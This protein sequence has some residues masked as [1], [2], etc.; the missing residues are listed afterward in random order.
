M[1]SASV[2][3]VRVN[4]TESPG[5]SSS[6]TSWNG[7]VTAAVRSGSPST[8]CSSARESSSAPRC[9]RTSR[10]VSVSLPVLVS[11]PLTVTATPGSSVR[12]SRRVSRTLTGR[13][14]AA[15]S[16][17]AGSPG[18]AV[19]TGGSTASGTL[20]TPASARAIVVP[21]VARR[22]PRTADRPGTDRRLTTAPRR[23][24]SPRGRLLCSPVSSPA[25]SRAVGE[26]RGRPLDQRPLVGV[27]EPGAELVEG[28]PGDLGH[29]DV[30]VGQSSPDGAQQEVVHGL[31]HPAAVGDEPEVDDA[32][33]GDDLADDA[34]L[35]G[36]LPDGGVL[37]G[38]ALLDV[39]LG[40]RPQQPAA[41][42]GAA[43]E[44]GAR[45]RDGVVRDHQAPG[46]GLV[47]P[48]QPAARAP[49]PARPSH[50]RRVARVR[51]QLREHRSEEGRWARSRTGVHS[52][53]HYPGSSCPVSPPLPRQLPSPC[54]PPS[55]RPCA[56]SSTSPPS[57]PGWGS[58][59]PTPA[60]RCT[61]SV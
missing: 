8:A 16:V 34:G 59:S 10:S 6:A 20:S 30:G 55:R 51:R 49:S 11:S 47:D 13:S 40:Q 7:V 2:V 33:R 57:W 28:N 4:D 50:A 29:L 37:R 52:P 19:A 15:A 43:D 21:R 42:V 26:E 58:A 48:P 5:R 14:S 46:G 3:V 53:R 44:G 25:R 24:S 12:G 54:R 17:A 22:G 39:A 1:A 18:A 27:G 45:P 60:S 23:R 61:S 31:V 56:S 38:L 32:E 41:A 35:L 9:S 36:D